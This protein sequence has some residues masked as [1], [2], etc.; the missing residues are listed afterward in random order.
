M[1]IPAAIILSLGLIISSS[2]IAASGRYEIIQVGP[3]GACAGRVD[4]W[5]GKAF[6]IRYAGNLSDPYWQPVRGGM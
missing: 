5:T 2:L 6:I 4:R 1:S 3:E